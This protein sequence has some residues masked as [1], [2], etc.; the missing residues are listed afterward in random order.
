MLVYVDRITDRL[1][2]TFEFVFEA[3]EIPFEIT[4]NYGRFISEQGLKFNYSNIDNVEV[5]SL[6]PSNLL[7]E[8]AIRNY[9][10]NQKE[11]KNE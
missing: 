9:N 10:L 7:F 6:V 2:Y 8:T 3:Q 1:R 5:P 11:F 4:D